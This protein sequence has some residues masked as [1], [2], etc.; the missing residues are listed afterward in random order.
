ME[1]LN[2][3]FCIFFECRII[4][5]RK[6]PRY[7]KNSYN[8]RSRHFQ[9]V[10]CLVNLGKG[11]ILRR[12][13]RKTTYVYCPHSFGCIHSVLHKIESSPNFAFSFNSFN[14]NLSILTRTLFFAQRLWKYQKSTHCCFQYKNNKTIEKEFKNTKRWYATVKRGVHISTNAQKRII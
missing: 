12:E 13:R 3:I 6:N 8:S 5:F 7:L 2:A 1:F 11:R 14:K 10:F 9:S 4:E